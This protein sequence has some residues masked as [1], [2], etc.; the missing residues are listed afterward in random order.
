M[1]DFILRFI[2]QV[3]AQTQH[4]ELLIPVRVEEKKRPFGHR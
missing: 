2:R 3:T 1:I 4:D